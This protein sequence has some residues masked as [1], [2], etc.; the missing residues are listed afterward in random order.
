MTDPHTLHR[1]EGPDTSTDAAYSIDPTRLE[2]TVYR[3]IHSFG[4]EGCISDEVRAQLPH[5]AYSSVTARYRKLLDRRH[6]LDTGHRRP[7]KSGR[8]QR[9][10][11]SRRFL[12]KS[13]RSKKKASVVSPATVVAT[14]LPKRVSAC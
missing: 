9:A 8:G 5:L 13:S 6:I 1:R 4:K 3:V 12:M 10:S 7:G 14:R 11:H 2:R